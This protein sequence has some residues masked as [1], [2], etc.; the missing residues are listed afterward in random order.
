MGT[1][2]YIKAIAYLTNDKGDFIIATGMAREAEI[3]KGMH[4]AQLTGST[5]SYARKYCLSGLFL[6]DDNADP[7]SGSYSEDKKTEKKVDHHDQ[8]IKEE[9]S[10]RNLTEEAGSCKNLAELAVW[11]GNLPEEMKKKGSPA[12]GVKDNRKEEIQAEQEESNKPAE[13]NEQTTSSAHTFES[14]KAQTLAKL[15]DIAKEVGVT[16]YSK[17]NKVTLIISII[18][19]VGE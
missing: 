16:G 6:I 8:K 14:L 7:D 19:I 2:N 10:G 13:Q 15:K 9:L 17:M 11:Y 12:V 18:K 1:H 5:S 4:D 3:Q